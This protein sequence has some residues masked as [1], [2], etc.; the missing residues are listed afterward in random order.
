LCRRQV[1]ECGF[2]DQAVDDA[3]RRCVVRVRHVDSRFRGNDGGDGF[4]CR[5]E[6]LA[7]P[8]LQMLVRCPHWIA[9]PARG[10][11][12]ASTAQPAPSGG[13][14]TVCLHS[15]KTRP[16]QHCAPGMAHRPPFLTTASGHLHPH[17]GC[18]TSGTSHSATGSIGRD[19]RI[20]EAGDSQLPNRQ[21]K[22]PYGRF[23]SRWS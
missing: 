22:V 2:F 9:I 15:R 5:P 18:Q 16:F 19:C 3:G 6:S 13:C 21:R 8:N 23:A 17:S 11:P 20:A 1:A 10:N 7:R 12:D 4:L 14:G